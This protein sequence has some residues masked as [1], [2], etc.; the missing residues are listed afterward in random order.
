MGDH[1]HS[2]NKVE[3][4]AIQRRESAHRVMPFVIAL[5][6]NV[7][8]YIGRAG[9]YGAWH[10]LYFI[11]CAFRAFTAFMLVAAVV[12]LP[13]ALGVF[14]NPSVAPMPWWFFLLSALGM[15]AFAVVYNLFLDWFA[16]PGSEDPF[17]RYRPRTSR[18]P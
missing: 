17:D 5:P 1:T 16:P 15:F 18:K 3:H 9:F 6:F 12:M 2:D 11:A 14:V 10:L 4:V 8:E 7:L 13:M